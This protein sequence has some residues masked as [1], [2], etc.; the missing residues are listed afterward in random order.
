MPRSL[1]LTAV[2]ALLAVTFLFSVPVSRAD[3][4]APSND[5][6]AWI[7]QVAEKLADTAVTALQDSLAALYEVESPTIY[8]IEKTEPDIF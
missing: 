3:N 1:I 5:N 4:F 8:M 2:A 7:V 6:A